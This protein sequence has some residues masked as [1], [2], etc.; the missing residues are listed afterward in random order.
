MFTGSQQ[1]VSLCVESADD[2]RTPG[3]SSISSWVHI[4]LHYTLSSFEVA[5]G[6]IGHFPW[7]V[8]ALNSG[9]SLLCKRV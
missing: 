2:I 4:S 9:Y 1:L 6:T 8:P 3:L 7:R 5:S